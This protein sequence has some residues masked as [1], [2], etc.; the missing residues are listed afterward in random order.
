LT[1]TTLQKLALSPR[2]LTRQARSGLDLR[3]DLQFRREQKLI[4]IG[5]SMGGAPTA[6]VD[7]ME[8][9]VRGSWYATARGAGVSEHDCEVIA[10]AFAYPGFRQSA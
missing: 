9:R 7:Q 4:V 6:I 5:T 10:R 1:W 2:P 8:Q 3:Y